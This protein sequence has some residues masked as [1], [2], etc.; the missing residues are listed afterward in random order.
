MKYW[1]SD[2]AYTQRVHKQAVRDDLL[3]KLIPSVLACTRVRHLPS[4]YIDALY[5]TGLLLL[6]LRMPL[7]LRALLTSNEVLHERLD[8]L[9]GQQR[10]SMFTRVFV[11]H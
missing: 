1:S 8:V 5:S 7:H 4:A 3:R 2:Y 10:V 11:G 6:A 9:H